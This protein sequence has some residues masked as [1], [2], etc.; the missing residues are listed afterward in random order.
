MEIFEFKCNGIKKLFIGGLHGNEGKFTEIVLKDFINLL[1]EDDYTGNIVVIPKLV[2]NSRYIS[3]L[4][5]KYYE[6]DEGKA[7]IN[8]IENY[9][10]NVY[11]ELHA[12]KKENYKKENESKKT[13]GIAKKGREEG[14]GKKGKGKAEGEAEGLITGDYLIL[15]K[16]ILESNFELPV[17][18]KDK[19]GLSATVEIKIGAGGK[20]VSY[21]FLKKS[22]NGDFNRAVEK[23]LKI[24]SPLPVDKEGRV[25]VEFK[26]EGIKSVK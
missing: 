5:E 25:V 12:Y 9:K 13:E 16:K 21:K 22:E 8:I 20:I 26:A 1:K 2:E 7:L 11:F 24:S 19:K 6:T 15:I 18:L 4:S 23:C 3:T 10:P 14:E 17:Y